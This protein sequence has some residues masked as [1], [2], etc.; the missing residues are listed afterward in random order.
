MNKKLNLGC[1][2]DIRVGHDNVDI[3]K[4]DESVIVRDLNK[5]EWKLKTGHYEVVVMN[6]ILEHLDNPIE[7]LNKVRK[8]MVNDGKLIICSPHFTSSC[9][10]GDLEHKFFGYNHKIFDDVDNFLVV[11]KRIVFGKK[12]AVWNHVIEYI[13]NL[14]PDLYENSVLRIFPALDIEVT[15]IKLY[16]QQW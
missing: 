9:V 15:L 12:Y 10:H 5:K 6:H 2:T 7:V 16:E 1:G 11:D 14:F 3:K 13:A 4:S 8:L